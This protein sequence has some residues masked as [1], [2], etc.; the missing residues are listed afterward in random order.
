MILQP[1]DF[2]SFYEWLMRPEAFLESAF[3]QGIVLFILAIVIG[4]MVGL[5]HIGEPLRTRRGILRRCP[6]RTGS[7]SL[8][9]TW[10]FGTPSIRA[11][12]TGIQGGDSPQSLVCGGLVCGHV[13]AG[14]LVFESGEQ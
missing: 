13:A 8:R 3:L 2:W 1:E 14:W 11:R 10:H 7:D 12:P 5:H 6:R 9:S 4:L